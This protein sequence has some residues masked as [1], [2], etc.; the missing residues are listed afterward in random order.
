MKNK[1]LLNLVLAWTVVGALLFACAAR[2]ET[3]DAF[4]WSPPTAPEKVMF[5]ATSASLVIDMMQT[6]DIKN[7]QGMFETNPVL[8]KHPSDMLIVG[9]FSSIIVGHSVAFYN[10]PM[11]VRIAL[12]VVIMTFEARTIHNNV[13]RGYSLTF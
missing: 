10:L 6:L 12:D 5:V 3:F 11:P 9:Y 4:K 2:A 7:H 8:G 13:V 1:A